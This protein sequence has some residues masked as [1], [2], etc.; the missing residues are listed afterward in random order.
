[1]STTVD[2]AVSRAFCNCGTDPVSS[3]VFAGP[4]S[5]DPG[6]NCIVRSD[7]MP[8]NFTES[9]LLIGWTL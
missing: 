1:V 7:D 3:E 5:R 6:E 8:L 9:Y 2:S 4:S